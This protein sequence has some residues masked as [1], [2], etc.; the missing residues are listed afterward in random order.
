MSLQGRTGDSGQ[1]SGPI[2][3]ETR[4]GFVHGSGPGIQAMRRDILEGEQIYGIFGDR[5]GDT[6]PIGVTNPRGLLMGTG[7]GGGRGAL[8][9]L[10]LRPIRRLSLLAPPPHPTSE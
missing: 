7:Y 5:R 4:V 9:S 6:A 3:P 2:R 1:L 10:A 8:A